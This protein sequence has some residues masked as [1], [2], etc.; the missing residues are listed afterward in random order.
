MADQPRELDPQ[1]VRRH[2]ITMILRRAGGSGET[3]DELELRELNCDDATR[4]AV[5]E[6]AHQLAEAGSLGGLRARALAA[7]EADERARVLIAAIPVE[8]G[9]ALPTVDDPPTEHESAG[10][11]AARIRQRMRDGLVSNRGIDD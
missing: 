10:G 1:Q 2:A 8:F 5:R 3:P 7:R 9:D 6:Q 4:D 11:L